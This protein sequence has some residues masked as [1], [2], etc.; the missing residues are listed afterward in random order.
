M[1]DL[2]NCL[3]IGDLRVRIAERFYIE[4][5]C[6]VL[7][8]PL[9]TADIERIHK[10]RRHAV[11]DQRVREQVVCA[12]IDVL[13]RDDMPAALCEILDRVGDCRRT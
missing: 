11:I 8:R 10:S 6:V 2:R 12:A 7:Y 9:K 4:C 3:D 1:R 5:L 13:C